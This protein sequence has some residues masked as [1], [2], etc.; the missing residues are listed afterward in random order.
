MSDFCVLTDKFTG[1]RPLAP[2]LLLFGHSPFSKTMRKLMCLSHLIILF[3]ITRLSWYHV[4]DSAYS[5]VSMNYSLWA[6]LASK[7][8]NLTWN[9]IDTF[10][11]DRSF[12][13]FI[14]FIRWIINIICALLNMIRNPIQNIHICMLSYNPSIIIR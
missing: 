4:I 6:S 5:W 11:W 2:P 8:D 7:D 14:H 3:L 9:M 13:L 10:L 12:F 1:Q